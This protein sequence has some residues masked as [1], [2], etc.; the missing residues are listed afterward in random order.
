MYRY[1]YG[2]IR[3]FIYI[4]IY[5]CIY[6]CIYIYTYIYICIYI[7]ILIFLH[8]HVYTFMYVYIYIYMYLFKGYIYIYICICVIFILHT[9][10]NGNAQSRWTRVSARRRGTAPGGA[11]IPWHGTATPSGGRRSPGAASCCASGETSFLSVG[12]FWNWTR[13]VSAFSCASG[14][15]GLFFWLLCVGGGI[16]RAFSRNYREDV[17]GF[18]HIR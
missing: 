14:E 3:V 7:Y 9:L 16:N 15:I 10:V 1:I 18:S 8:I 17:W 6:I 4:Y 11:T 2:Y 5:T 12:V 13:K